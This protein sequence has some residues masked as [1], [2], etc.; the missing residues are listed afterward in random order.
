VK[1]PAPITHPAAGVTDAHW[2]ML[3]AGTLL[4]SQGEADEVSVPVRRPDDATRRTRAC[5]RRHEQAPHP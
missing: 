4:S 1:D 5:R 3:S 2:L